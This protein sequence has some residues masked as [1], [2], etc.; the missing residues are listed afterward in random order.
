MSRAAKLTFYSSIVLT[1]A[2][3]IGKNDTHLFSG[4]FYL[5]DQDFKTRRAGI[6]RD[7]RK[8]TQQQIENEVEALQQE[9]LRQEL[10][11]T[12]VVRRQD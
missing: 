4:V 10:L 7:N 9:K 6:E 8:R 5:K 12:Q 3:I 2:T 11:K 1:G